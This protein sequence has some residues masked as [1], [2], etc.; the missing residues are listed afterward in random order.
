M[1]LHT[2]FRRTSPATVVAM[3]AL[4][5]ALTGTAVATSS[6]LITGKQIK[7]SSIT[8][9]DVKNRSL[10]PRDF[11]GS[12][13]GP[14]G[15]TGPAGSLGPQGPQGPQGP[16]GSQGATGIPGPQGPAGATDVTVRTVA[17]EPG[18]TGDGFY[19]LA[20]DCHL[21]ER[22]TGGGAAVWNYLAKYATIAYSIP[23]P[24]SGTPT[25]WYVG[26]H[27]AVADDDAYVQ[28][29]VVCAAP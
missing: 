23:D 24:S 13:Q 14:R 28:A 9:A 1:M 18:V 8:S 22:A 11:R 15:L 3:L 10:T 21:G 2:R 29:Y 5:A 27:T 12:V 19:S 6:T 4:F 7:D 16:A 26:V 17:R 20:P 25:G